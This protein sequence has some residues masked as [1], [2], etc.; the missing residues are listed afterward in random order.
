MTF[1]LPLWRRDVLRMFRV[2]VRYGAV[3]EL[4]T[5]DFAKPVIV[6]CNHQSFLDGPILAFASPR[7]MV[8]PVNPKQSV[9]NRFTRNALAVLERLGL[10]WTVVMNSDKPWSVRTLAAAL[11]ESRAVAV[12]PAGRICA[13]HE[14]EVEKPGVE[15]LSARTGAAVIRARISGAADSRLFAK[16][17]TKIWPKI[18]VEF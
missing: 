10:G 13:P 6:C 4:L 3:A 16:A 8:F 7:K 11:N 17:G 9:D 15:W 1:R 12:F 14:C 5:A 2:E 18:T